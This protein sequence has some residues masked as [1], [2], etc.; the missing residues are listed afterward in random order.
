MVPPETQKPD[1][2]DSVPSEKGDDVTQKSSSHHTVYLSCK[3]AGSSN[4]PKSYHERGIKLSDDRDVASLQNQSINLDLP[5]KK[6][7]SDQT[8]HRELKL[9]VTVPISEEENYVPNKSAQHY[10]HP[11]ITEVAEPQIRSSK[12]DNLGKSLMN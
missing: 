4:E 10:K 5:N 11:N 9:G 8:L 3:D 2:P 12:V 7:E 6:R 1:E